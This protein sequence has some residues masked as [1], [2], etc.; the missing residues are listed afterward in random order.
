MFRCTR[1]GCGWQAIAASEAAAR[2]QYLR[3]LVGEHTTEVDADVPDGK[4]QV[5]YGD[6]EEWL[7]VTLEEA[8]RLHEAYHAGDD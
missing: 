7:T 8:K 6:R 5:R 1:P 2:D 3:H 4:V